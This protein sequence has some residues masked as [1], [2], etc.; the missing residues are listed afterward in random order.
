M[1]FIGTL[2]AGSYDLLLDLFFPPNCVNC[3]SQGN[4]LCQDCLNSFEPAKLKCLRCGRKNP[5]G[6]YCPRCRRDN[7]PELVLSCFRYDGDVKRVIHLFK[8]SDATIL[9][10]YL[11]P[12]MINLIG[13]IPSYKSFIICPIP[14]SKKRKNMRGYNQS[15]IL[16]KKICA[17]L[18]LGFANLLARKDNQL[19]QVIADSKQA[20]RANVKGVFSLKENCLGKNI[21]LIDDVI[22][23]GATVEEATKVLISS[24][25]K[26][27]I[28]VS[29]ALA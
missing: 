4:F 10:D 2:L 22:T 27:V 7:L 25:A 12:V 14:L 24:G 20:R 21:I 19:S 1:G 3:H 8:Y 16:S 15:E 17:I 23:T 29:V 5:F 18:G 26:K 28:A 11:S 9:G 6:I 13:R